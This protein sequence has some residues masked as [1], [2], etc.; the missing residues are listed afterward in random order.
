MGAIFDRTKEHLGTADAQIIQV[1]RRY[2]HM[3]R[4]LQEGVTPPGVE[5]PTL[6]RKRGIAIV[7]PKGE[8]WVD[9]VTAPSREYVSTW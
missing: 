9:A 7:L 2:M 8:N 1:R 5:D 3:V 4:Q 6:F